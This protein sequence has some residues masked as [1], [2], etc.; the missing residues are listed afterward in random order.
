MTAPFSPAPEEF[1]ASLAGLREAMSGPVRACPIDTELSAEAGFR[2]LVEL[3]PA[4]W[5]D[6]VAWDDAASERTGIPQD[7]T[8]RLWDVLYV[9]AGFLRRHPGGG[10]VEVWRY[11]RDAGPEDEPEPV[12]L[13]VTV[14]R[15]LVT[16][17]L[18]ATATAG[19]D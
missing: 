11:R 13:R 18:A 3:T 17:G 1:A 8:G 19:D 12:L 15:A 2:F 7:E 16:I 5:T 6:C 10:D 4:A 9:S 14:E